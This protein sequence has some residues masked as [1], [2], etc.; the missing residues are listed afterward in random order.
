MKY[1]NSHHRDSCVINCPAVTLNITVKDLAQ[2][3]AI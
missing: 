2:V 3:P 1:S